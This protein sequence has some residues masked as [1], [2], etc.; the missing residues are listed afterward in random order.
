[1]GDAKPRAVTAEGT[2][3]GWVS[4][5]GRRLCV[6]TADGLD[7]LPAEGGPE[8][9]VPGATADDLVVRWH[10]DGGGLLVARPWDV[11]LR[12]ER[13]DLSTGKRTPF[14]TM[15]PADLTGAIQILPVAIANDT[16]V[17]G[18]G[19]RRMHSDLFLVK[20]AH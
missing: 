1:V 8:R 11:P 5:D 3:A 20:G 17:Y 19:A 16:R 6:Q 12:V 10:P 18:Y 14:R 4:P 9:K 13:L 2:T 15:G 7:V